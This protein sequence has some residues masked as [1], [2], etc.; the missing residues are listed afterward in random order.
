MG[1][2]KKYCQCRKCGKMIVAGEY[3][4]V[5]ACSCGSTEISVF[6]ENN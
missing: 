6:S 4:H 5:I 2:S 3:E 1:D